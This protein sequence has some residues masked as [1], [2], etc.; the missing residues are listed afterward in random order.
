V[1]NLNFLLQKFEKLK[2]QNLEKSCYQGAEL[3]QVENL[4]LG[5]GL[6]LLPPR[7]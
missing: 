5:E 3:E 4:D 6:L 1:R 7:R 2:D